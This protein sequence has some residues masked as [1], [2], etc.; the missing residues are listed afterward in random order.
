MRIGLEVCG[1]SSGRRARHSCPR[2]RRE[3]ILSVYSREA[4]AGPRCGVKKFLLSYLV[5]R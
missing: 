3:L 4:I 1:L 5:T 2:G